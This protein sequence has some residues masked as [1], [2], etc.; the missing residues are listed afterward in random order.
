MP[1][2]EIE[3]KIKRERQIDLI[4]GVDEVG[5]GSLAGP[6]VAAAVVFD[7]LNDTEELLHEVDDS[8]KISPAKRQRLSGLIKARALDF[9]FGLV[10][11]DEIDQLGVGRANVL[12]FERALNGLKGCQFALIDGR[13]FGGEFAYDFLCIEKGESKSLS[14]AAASIIAKVYRDSLMI[15]LHDEM[16]RFGFAQN[17]GYG[18]RDHMDILRSN[19][20]SAS[21][22]KSFL[23]F[24]DAR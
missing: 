18:T 11:V 13:H 1:N 20:P 5:R 23:G 15:Q 2:F 7:H 19:G 8:K 12:A 4:A 24:L 16:P 6:L 9:A 22:R 21:H 14:I 3:H 17:K 10:D